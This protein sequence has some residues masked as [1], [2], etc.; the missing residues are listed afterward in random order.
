MYL[1]MEQRVSS[2]ICPEDTR[3][4]ELDVPFCRRVVTYL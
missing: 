2:Y 1:L 4:L 3:N